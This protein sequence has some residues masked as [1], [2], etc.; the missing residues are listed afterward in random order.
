MAVFNSVQILNE[1]FRERLTASYRNAF[2]N[3]A[4]DDNEYCNIIRAAANTAVE[5]ISTSDAP[6]HDVDHTM[7]VTLVGQ[8]IVRG[9]LLSKGDV[10]PKDWAHFTIALLF[11]DVGYVRG[12]CAGDSGPV[13]VTDTQ[14]GSVQIPIGSTDAYLTPYHVE[15]GKMFVR[16]RFAATPQIDPKI[17]THSIE[18]TRFPV[19]ADEDPAETA[20]WPG[21][22]RAAD[23]IGQMADPDYLR[24]LPAL[25]YEF[26]ETGA[27]VKMGNATPAD[28][29]DKYPDFF[30]NMVRPYIGAGIDFLK[31]THEGRHWL[32]GLYSHVFYQEHRALL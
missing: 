22:V 11:H 32:S 4:G 31:V 15:R 7:L 28:L 20:D 1:A 3:V 10:T 2:G 6:Y 27:N 23:L 9:R 13:A 12:V 26:E 14:G 5:V 8:E 17:I 18:N 30:W 16:A 25:F 29:R 19:P 21:L 24:K